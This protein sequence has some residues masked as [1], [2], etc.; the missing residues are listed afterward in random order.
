MDVEKSFTNLLTKR[1]GKERKGKEQK[2]NFFLF[3]NFSLS[4]SSIIIITFTTTMSQAL[5]I[6]WRF[7]QDLQF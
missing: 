2:K 1:K 5:Y 7:L 3:G 4:P 6:L